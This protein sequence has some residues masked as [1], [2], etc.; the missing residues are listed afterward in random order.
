[1]NCRTNVLQCFKVHRSTSRY[2]SS[3]LNLSPC[4]GRF[5]AELSWACVRQFTGELLDHHWNWL[6]PH[7][8]SNSPLN[9]RTITTT[10]LNC[11]TITSTTLGQIHR[12]IVL[13]CVRQLQFTGELLPH[14]Q[15]C[16]NWLA[17]SSYAHSWGEAFALQWVLTGAWAVQWRHKNELRKFRLQE[18][19]TEWMIVRKRRGVVPFLAR[20]K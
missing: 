15:P 16:A 4:L 8:N 20:A 5:T 2:K 12:W 6:S 9:C 14:D 3:S 10:T 13:A 19:L 17:G 1:M 11:R 18:T 7:M